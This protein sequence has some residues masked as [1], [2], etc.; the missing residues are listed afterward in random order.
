VA[1][2]ASE[3]NIP[4]LVLTHFSPRYEQDKGPLS[5]AQVEEEAR[6]VY[7]G[8]LFLARD[9]DRYVLD[10]HGVLAKVG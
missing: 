4:N 10:R 3:A 7:S 8:R 2:F 5:L 1:R 6:G 9:F